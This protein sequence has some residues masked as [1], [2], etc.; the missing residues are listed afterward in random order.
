[1]SDLRKLWAE[2]GDSLWEIQSHHEYEFKITK[3][4]SSIKI[5]KIY[6]VLFDPLSNKKSHI[7]K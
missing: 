5:K 7:K 6:L 2:Y 3:A 4:L 1:M